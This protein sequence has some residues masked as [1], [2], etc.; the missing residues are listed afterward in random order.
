MGGKDAK[1]T[2]DWAV[3]EHFDEREWSQ[4]ELAAAQACLEKAEYWARCAQAVVGEGDGDLACAR[5]LLGDRARDVATRRA[6]AAD[7]LEEE[8][9]KIA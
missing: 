8:N 9:W 6:S 1:S 3:G 4:S 7:I 2:C 5:R